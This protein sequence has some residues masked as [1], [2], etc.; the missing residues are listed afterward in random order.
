MKHS[1][2]D[3][4]CK[5]CI[6]GEG[7]PLNEFTNL[8]VLSFCHFQKVNGQSSSNTSYASDITHKKNVTTYSCLTHSACCLSTVIRIIFPKKK[9]IASQKTID[10]HKRLLQ[11]SRIIKSIISFYFAVNKLISMHSTQKIVVKMNTTR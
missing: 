2:Q 7:E 9:A 6:I 1:Y 3:F 4:I 8:N 11:V 5:I 10:K